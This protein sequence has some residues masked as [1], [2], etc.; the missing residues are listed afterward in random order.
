[1]EIKILKKYFISKL[2]GSSF[3]DLT[4][5]NYKKALHEGQQPFFKIVQ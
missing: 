4:V 5:K 1:M 3:Q 2:P